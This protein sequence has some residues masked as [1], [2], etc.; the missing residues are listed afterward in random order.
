[1]LLKG[2]VRPIL[3]GALGNHWGKLIFSV[4]HVL[5]FITLYPLILKLLGRAMQLDPPEALK[6]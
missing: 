2:L 6:S 1:V 3:T 4:I 5:W